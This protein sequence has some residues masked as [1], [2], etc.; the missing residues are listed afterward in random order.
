[1]VIDH[2]SKLNYRLKCFFQDKNALYLN[3]GQASNLALIIDSYGE[4]SI[5]RTSDTEDQK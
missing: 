2:K 1:M 3:T 5:V 4:S